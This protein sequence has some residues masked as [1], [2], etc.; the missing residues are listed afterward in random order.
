MTNDDNNEPDNS[1]DEIAEKGESSYCED[2]KPPKYIKPV[3]VDNTIRV[4]GEAYLNR[5]KDRPKCRRVALDFS[6]EL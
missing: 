4:K 1:H 3:F 6:D 2:W 5:L